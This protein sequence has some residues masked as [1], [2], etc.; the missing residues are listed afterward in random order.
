M[1]IFKI[2]TFL[3]LIT[4]LVSCSSTPKTTNENIY[5]KT[6]ELEFLSGPRIAFDGLFPNKK[7]KIAFNKDTQKVEGNDSCNGYS[8]GYTLNGDAI[9]FGEP[10]MTTMMYCGEG[11]TF[12]LN[13]MKKI[14]K[15]HIDENGKLNLMIDN[16]P[17]M[18]FKEVK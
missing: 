12:F 10:G 14:N 16:I 7:P 15:Y 2:L 1:K 4:V 13:T 5:G 6:W 18:R 11:E 3:M 17:M 9:S 8:A